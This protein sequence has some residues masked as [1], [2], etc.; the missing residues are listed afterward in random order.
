[1]NIMKNNKYY[2]LNDYLMSQR[3]ENV[4]TTYT[5]MLD[6]LTKLRNMKIRREDINVKAW[7][8]FATLSPTLGLILGLCGVRLF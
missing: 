3:S 2:G 5:T 8:V 7:I 6:K 1:M 4:R